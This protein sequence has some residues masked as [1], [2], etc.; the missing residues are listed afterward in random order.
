MC[1]LDIG[2]H[3]YV[4][5]I[6]IHAGH[7]AVG[8]GL[9]KIAAHVD[10]RSEYPVESP[11]VLGRCGERVVAKRY[12]VAVIAQPSED[13]G[14]YVELLHQPLAHTARHLARRVEDYDRHM[15]E[16]GL[17]L[18]FVMS[19][20]AARMI[21][22][23]H[24]DGVVIPWLLRGCLKKPSERIVGITYALVQLVYAL[25]LEAALVTLGDCKRMM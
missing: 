2:G 21:G 1:V 11:A 25:V 12:V 17:G 18:I 10:L 7:I 5:Y 16:S 3:E 19:G 8:I 22:R 9:E 13:G 23:E 14:E 20:L 15:V 4:V 24:K 6:V